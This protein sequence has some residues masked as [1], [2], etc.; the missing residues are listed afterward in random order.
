VEIKP[1]FEPIT[2]AAT[3]INFINNQGGVGYISIDEVLYKIT[4]E[5][6]EPNSS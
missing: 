6:G 5:K 2:D 1:L 4:V 3:L